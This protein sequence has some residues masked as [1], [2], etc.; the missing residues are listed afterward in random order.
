[1][2]GS[3]AENNEEEN[4]QKSPL[5]EDQNQRHITSVFHGQ[6][7]DRTEASVAPA[8][9]LTRA[10]GKFCNDRKHRESFQPQHDLSAM[11]VLSL[12]DSE[13]LAD[14]DTNK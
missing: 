13:A 10:K 14:M 8:Y 6:T 9:L 12:L 5:L 11:S 7:T 3:D 4:V 2:H 1:M